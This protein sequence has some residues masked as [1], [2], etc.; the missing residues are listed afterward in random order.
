MAS[1][2][3][4]EKKESWMMWLGYSLDGVDESCGRFSG[5]A[6][7]GIWKGERRTRG[8]NW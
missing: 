5:R 2:A 4:E 8:L 1:R 3:V 6:E 7:W